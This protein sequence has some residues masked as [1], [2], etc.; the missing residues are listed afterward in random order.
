MDEFAALSQQR[1]VQSQRNGFFQR[2][3]IPIIT[4]CGAVVSKEDGPRPST[5][6]EI[7][8]SLKTFFR[9]DGEVTAGNC[10]ALNDG[11]AAMVVMS[12]EKARE[13]GISIH[14]WI[15]TTL[16]NGLQTAKDLRPRNHVCSW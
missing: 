6:I 16:L 3:I 4:P 11:A 9:P 2:E 15:M 12:D 7:L 13:L 1:A 14:A 5:T 8:A 10:G